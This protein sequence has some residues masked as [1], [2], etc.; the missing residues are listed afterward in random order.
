MEE[1][2]VKPEDRPVVL[3][4][5][6]AAERAKA[7]NKGNQGVYCGAAI[8]LKDGTI[9]TG[10]NSA[11]MH[12]ASSLVMNAAKQL[13]DV[14]DKLHLL[15]PAIIDSIRNLKTTILKARQVSLDLEE[16]LI[17][18]SISAMT[19]SAA[20]VAM[21]KLQDLRGCEMHMTHIP[22]PGDEAGLRRL[23]VNLTSEPIFSSKSLF[24]T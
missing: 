5:R 3:P 16:T 20:Q 22:T 17:A 19:N 14:P 10:E 21:E 24:I 1:S 15:S 13:A 9:V 2:N 7:K 12:A 18:L 4:A 8:E 11:L 23:G 6:E